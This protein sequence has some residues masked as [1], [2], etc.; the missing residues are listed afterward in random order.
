MNNNLF[1]KMFLLSTVFIDALGIGI[2][3]PIIAPLLVDNNN[4]FSFATQLWSKNLIFGLVGFTYFFAMFLGSPILGKYSDSIGRKKI[5]VICLYG[6]FFG[7]AIS[8]VAIFFKSLTIFILSRFISG[9][10]SGS[11]PIAQALLIDTAT[12]QKQLA[13][14][15]QA[16]FAFCMGL[17]VGPLICNFISKTSVA[18]SNLYF[19]VFLLTAILTFVNASFFMAFFTEKNPISSKKKI[20]FTAMISDFKKILGVSCIRKIL[21]SYLFL[22]L[23]WAIYSQCIVLFLVEFFS[24][25]TKNISSFMFWLA[26]AFSASLM[27]ITPLL[28][29]VSSKK[30][31]SISIIII[32][33]AAL[34]TF[35]HRIP[36]VWMFAIITSITMSIAQV[37]FLNHLSDS[38]EE[39][40]RG[41]ALS[42]ANSM[43]AIAWA[44]GSTL[45]SI[46]I[47]L[48]AIL[49]F[50]IVSVCS[51]C[52]FY[53]YVNNAST[54]ERSA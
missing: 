46:S 37:F 21:V 49:P 5:L 40:Q 7:F 54:K 18:I 26:I 35:D 42:L 41:T 32:G 29:T 10:L 47:S 16:T 15:S 13:V 27:L 12:K 22:Q 8:S 44:M 25:T 23:A 28:K 34:A 20:V 11:L 50:V 33:I 53:I 36:L 3:T 19:L 24:Y 43:N 4:H 51:I 6:S 39:T 48:T 1:N 31:I 45:G 2:A 52:A 30:V 9:F 38:V 14:I 17:I